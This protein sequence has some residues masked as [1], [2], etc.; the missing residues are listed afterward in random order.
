MAAIT[1]GTDGWRALIAEDYTFDNVRKVALAFARYY[2]NHPKADNG[3][4]VGGDARFGSQDFAAA[5]AQVI[6]S[7][8]IKVW[9]AEN[10]VST[11][12]VS[13]PACTCTG[14]AAVM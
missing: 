6:A 12:M 5:A 8:G 1:F 9:L 11:P 10:V 2:R 3:V 4:V 14:S 7:Q 13:L